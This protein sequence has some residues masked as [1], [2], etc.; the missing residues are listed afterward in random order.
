MN[1]KTTNDTP[2]DRRWQMIVGGK[3]ADA[4]SG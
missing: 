3:S 4:A 2:L 1:S